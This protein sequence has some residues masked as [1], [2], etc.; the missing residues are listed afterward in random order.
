MGIRIS[1]VTCGTCLFS[2]LC[3]Y[4]C[5]D[6]FVPFKN[7]YTLLLLNYKTITVSI[8]VWKPNILRLHTSII[9]SSFAFFCKSRNIIYA[10][11]PDHFV[12]TNICIHYNNHS[13]ITTFITLQNSRLFMVF[14]LQ[15]SDP[16]SSLIFATRSTDLFPTKLCTNQTPRQALRQK[17]D[18]RS[19]ILDWLYRNQS[20]RSR[21]G[22][23]ENNFNYFR[24]VMWGTDVKCIHY[25][26]FGGNQSNVLFLIKKTLMLLNIR[27]VRIRTKLMFFCTNPW[28]PFL[29]RSCLTMHSFHFSSSSP[30][31]SV[32]LNLSVAFI[33]IC[34]PQNPFRFALQT[35]TPWTATVAAPQ[36][37]AIVAPRT[38]VVAAPRTTSTAFEIP[39]RTLTEICCLSW[40]LL[41]LDVVV[42][43]ALPLTL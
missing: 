29:S 30:F 7:K 3:V 35:S 38:F 40:K 26:S 14:Q 18:I 11:L 24:S 2:C 43:A 16:L 12:F 20:N 13:I 27:S 15:T 4:L 17:W 39:Q 10:Y 23:F 31:C 32:N 5:V 41:H 8:W 19:G 21:C 22:N 9:T 28:N 36:A 42:V 25:I 37:S 6:T 34:E 1:G 33:S